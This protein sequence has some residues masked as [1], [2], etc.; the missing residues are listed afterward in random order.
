MIRYIPLP[1]DKSLFDEA[2]EL[3][4]V[5]YTLRFSWNQRAARWFLTVEDTD[6]VHLTTGRK[7]CA[8]MPFGR[9]ILPGQLWTLSIGE[10]DDDPGLRD[11][12]VRSL[13]LYVDEVDT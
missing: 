5:S 7:V 13:L 1:S 2:V 9:G 10:G 12:G 3:D 4:G 8:D 6:G 11:L